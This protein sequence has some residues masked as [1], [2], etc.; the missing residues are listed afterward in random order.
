ML[1]KIEDFKKRYVVSIKEAKV[2]LADKYGK[3]PRLVHHLREVDESLF[4]ACRQRFK[5][6]N[7]SFNLSLLHLA[8]GIK[9]VRKPALKFEK[10][11]GIVVVKLENLNPRTFGPTWIKRNSWI[12]YNSLI[13]ILQVS[14]NIEWGTF[15]DSL[16]EKWRQRWRRR[17]D[18]YWVID[19][20]LSGKKQRTDLS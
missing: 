11:V 1:A 20:S 5:K 13:K 19:E 12:E 3:K 6:K 7:G 15:V 9:F 8:L 14:D 18:G 17:V 4:Y 10:I 16:P 2:L